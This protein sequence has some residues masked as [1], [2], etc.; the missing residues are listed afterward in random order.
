MSVFGWVRAQTKSLFLQYR[1]IMDMPPDYD[2]IIKRINAFV[3][4]KISKKLD[5]T[6]IYMQIWKK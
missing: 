6:W 2:L 1:P 4:D 5:E 3:S